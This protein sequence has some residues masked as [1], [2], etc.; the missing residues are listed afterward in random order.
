MCVDP[1]SDC[2]AKT[3]QWK[4]TQPPAH[5]LSASD[6]A[7]NHSLDVELVKV[8]R[9]SV[10]TPLVVISSIAMTMIVNFL[11][12]SLPIS[13]VTTA[14][15]SNLYPV[16]ITP[17]GY[18]FSIWGLIYLGL[19]LYGIYQ[20][21]PQQRESSSMIKIGRW[22]IVSGI[23]NTSWILLWHYQQ[24][25]LSLLAMIVLLISLIKAYQVAYSQE[26]TSKPGASF[27]VRLP[28][29][30]YLGWICVAAAINIAVVLF[31]TGWRGEPLNE[32]AWSILVVGLITVLTASM[33]KRFHDYVFGTV[34]SWALIAIAV[35]QTATPEIR[36][37]ASI[38]VF[39]I[40]CM[41]AY[42]IYKG[43]NRK[44]NPRLI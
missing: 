11:A 26:I 44:Q 19:I 37:A 21:L 16:L 9:S 35:K 3:S 20:L 29:S 5:L 23:A 42:L 40:V 32:L 17:A 1:Q 30:L 10:L 27:S 6:V 34:V 39:I 24:V 7:S 41:I 13:G 12:V 28:I 8:M 22:M 14:E 2:I 43:L 31:T 33:L 18:A 38:A 15:L 4:Y 36:N 25:S